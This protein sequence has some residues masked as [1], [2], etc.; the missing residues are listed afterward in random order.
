MAGEGQEPS[1]NGTA[2][3]LRCPA[4]ELP[5]GSDVAVVAPAVP[6]LGEDPTL[7]SAEVAKGRASLAWWVFLTVSHKPTGTRLGVWMPGR[8]S[9]GGLTNRG[10]INSKESHVRRSQGLPVTQ[11]WPPSHGTLVQACAY[12]H[13]QNRSPAPRL[14]SFSLWAQPELGQGDFTPCTASSLAYTQVWPADRMT[15]H[16]ISG[17]CEGPFRWQRTAQGVKLSLCVW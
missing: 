17:D 15:L 7:C 4:S 11:S 2:L 8:G 3:W 1:K 12:H 10:D 13:T 6:T 16:P 9:S 14:G 5:L